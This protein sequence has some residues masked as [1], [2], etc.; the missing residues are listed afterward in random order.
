[1]QSHTKLLLVSYKTFQKFYTIINKSIL[2]EDEHLGKGINDALYDAYKFELKAGLMC[3]H[4][5]CR[6]Y[7]RRR[8]T[9]LGHGVC[10]VD[11][12]FCY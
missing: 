2:E 6:A 7:C 8:F 1:L 9:K 12:C 10:R 11:Y 5:E 3:R 4:D